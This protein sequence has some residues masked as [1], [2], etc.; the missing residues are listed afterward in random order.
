MKISLQQIANKID[1][2]L[3]P[4]SPLRPTREVIKSRFKMAHGSGVMD[5]VDANKRR[6]FKSWMVLLQK[7]GAIVRK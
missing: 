3:G 4:L 2:D 6:S 1:A 5:S 7:S